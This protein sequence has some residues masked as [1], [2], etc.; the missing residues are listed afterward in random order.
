M[1]SSSPLHSRRARLVATLVAVF[2]AL[3]L[4]LQWNDFYGFQRS[5]WLSG[6]Q[7]FGSHPIPG[8][9]IVNNGEH[10]IKQLIKNARNN[11]EALHKTRSLTLNDAATKYRQRR[12]RHPPPGFAAWFEAAQQRDVIVIE[13]FFD[14]I[15]H[16]TNPFWGL[17]PVEMRRQVH[18]QVEVIQVRAGN[19]TV[20]DPSSHP[21][22]WLQIWAA[23]VEDMGAGNIPDMDIFVNTM[24]ETRL[25]VPWEDIAKYITMEE[26]SRD[27]FSA[28]EVI[29]TYTPYDDIDTGAGTTKY[30]HKWITQGTD[31]YW[32]YAAAT[33][34]PSSLARKFKSLKGHFDDPIDK[35]YPL[36]RPAFVE[37]FTESMDFCTQPHLRG[38]HGTFIES[39]SMRT[40]LELM[41]IFGGSKL[42]RNNEILIPGAM[43]LTEDPFYEGGK[44]ES[45]PWDQKTTGMIW[46]GVASGGRNKA[47]N[48]WHF[49]RH[50]WVQMMNGSTVQRLEQGDADAAPTFQLLDPSTYGEYLPKLQEGRL[51]E[52]VST[53]SNIS[54]IN[55]E[56][57]PTDHDE[58]GAQVLT[59]PYTTPFLDLWPRVPMK[60]QYNFK[61]LPDVDGNSFS[62]RWR[63]FL[64][65][66]SCPLKATIY[67]E[68]HDDRM[69]PWVHFVPFDSSFQ[70]IYAIME[71]FLNHQDGDAD[72]ARIAQES[73]EW[74]AK[75]LRR[76]DMLLYVWRLLLEYAR[77][78]DP[79]RDHLG[80]VDD[81][82]S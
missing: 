70:D 51:G 74:A 78:M 55:L 34:P 49:H 9:T 52:W 30:P 39:V 27:I 25:L 31:K 36:D 24:D 53:F 19:V 14:R 68:W 54:F 6:S 77:V 16:D 21:Q 67:A 7:E 64:R 76:D 59:C 58:N 32:D 18:A 22:P 23:L 20:M 1:F 33:C 8:S 12:G 66:T 5:T 71:Y 40:S 10:P 80:F 79:K 37:N 60:D 29:S 46:R 38:M 4:L 13:D 47:D 50:R 42:L 75:T 2:F 35:L 26:A 3:G 44:D 43:Y 82:K 45:V 73:S 63:G 15:Y 61:Y 41:P 28:N 48:W 65:S 57:F 17:D 81:L 62:A 56:C 72:G 69:I 11:F